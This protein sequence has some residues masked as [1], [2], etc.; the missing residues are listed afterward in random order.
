MSVGAALEVI[1]SGGA[2]EVG[3][4]VLRILGWAAVAAGIALP[5][6]A[7]RWHLHRRNRITG[8]V[9]LPPA[10]EAVQSGPR[11]VCPWCDTRECI[12]KTLCNC[13]R[14]CGS[15]LCTVKEAS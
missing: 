7:L 10:D 13:A 2:A 5:L 6:L 8:L 3:A 14:P 15:W 4:A 11:E 12:D 1:A 9:I